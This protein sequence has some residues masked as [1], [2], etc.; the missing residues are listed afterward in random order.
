MINSSDSMDPEYIS[1]NFKQALEKDLQNF[2]KIKADYKV[3]GTST[4]YHKAYKNY[5]EKNIKILCKFFYG[6]KEC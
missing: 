4:I 3:T 1:K 5:I 2:K 6:K